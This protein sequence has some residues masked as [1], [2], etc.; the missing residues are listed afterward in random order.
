MEQ[1]PPET[2]QQEDKRPALLILED[3]EELQYLID[4]GRLIRETIRLLDQVLKSR[5]RQRHSQ[6]PCY[7]HAPCVFV[8]RVFLSLLRPR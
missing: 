4:E 5:A 1:P 3:S 8:L 7:I 6:C 2:V